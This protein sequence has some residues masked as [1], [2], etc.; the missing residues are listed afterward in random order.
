MMSD[1]RLPKLGACA[2]RCDVVHYPPFRLHMGGRMPARN[3]TTGH[4]T[5]NLPFPAYG[6]LRP[7][8][9]SIRMQGAVFANGDRMP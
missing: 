5:K 1:F 2:V 9:H 7:A 8:V 6:L 4:E 3:E